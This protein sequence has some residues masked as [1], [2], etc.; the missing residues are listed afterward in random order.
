MS[1]WL[2]SYRQK[3]AFAK[4]ANSADR[5]ARVRL[6]GRSAYISPD[7]MPAGCGI[8]SRCGNARWLAAGPVSTVC[9]ECEIDRLLLAGQRAVDPRLAAD[10]AEVGLHGKPLP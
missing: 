6:T 9:D 10:E 4:S 8:C 3:H 7:D 5:P 1:A 2:G